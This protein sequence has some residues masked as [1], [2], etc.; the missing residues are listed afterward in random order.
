MRVALT[1]AL[2]VAKRR[3]S[4]G[5]RNGLE[6]NRPRH[7]RRLGGRANLFAKVA[8]PQMLDEIVRHAAQK[9]QCP[10]R[11]TCLAPSTAIFAPLHVQAVERIVFDAPVGAHKCQH[12]GWRQPNLG[13]VGNIIAL[14]DF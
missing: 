11:S 1:C 5:H 14:F 12:L 4:D 13:H 3:E 6:N 8:A 7:D 2:V 9:T 10:Q